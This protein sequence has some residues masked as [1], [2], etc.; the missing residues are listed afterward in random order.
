MELPPEEQRQRIGITG[1]S[2]FLGTRLTERIVREGHRAVCYTR[3]LSRKHLQCTELRRY[4]TQGIDFSGIDTV[5]H[6]AGES[7]FGLWSEKKKER[8]LSSRRDGTR[9]VVESMK[10]A[11]AA[12]AENA[13]NDNARTQANGP[14]EQSPGHPGPQTLICASAVGFYGD[15]GEIAVDESAP[16]G[17]GF[18]ADV[19]RAWEAEAHRAEEAGI[20]LVIL[21]F[22]VILAREGGMLAKLRPIFLLGLGA[23][24]GSGQQW[25]SWIHA[26][27]A[28]QLIVHCITHEKIHGVLNAVSP[29]PLRNVDFTAAV[30]RK[31]DRKVHFHL[32]AFFIKRAFGPMSELILSS[33]RVIP[34]RLEEIGFPFHYPE[35]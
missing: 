35:L 25:V 29:H 17:T 14:G 26:G 11:R 21:R 2:G 18:L 15:T 5:V 22:G 6:L 23:T 27:D 31:W 30:A 16:A 10:A 12:A 19:T 34:R 1:A 20:R 28:A 3:D 8:I 7:I 33:S 13:K 9:A 24:M 32:P 4:D